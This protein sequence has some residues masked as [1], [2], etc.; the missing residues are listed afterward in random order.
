MCTEWLG[1][2]GEFYPDASCLARHPR[3]ELGPTE[4][5]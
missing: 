5:H 1:R 2:P 3:L 4:G